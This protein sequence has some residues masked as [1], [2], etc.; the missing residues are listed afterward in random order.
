MNA[1][2]ND[3]DTPL[4]VAAANGSKEVAELLLANKA[5]INATSKSG[6]PLHVA[7]TQGGEKAKDV[8]G[9]LRQR[10]GHE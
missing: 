8:A 1:K 5:D 3:G 2:S 7:L 9:L 4:H 10:G 6:T